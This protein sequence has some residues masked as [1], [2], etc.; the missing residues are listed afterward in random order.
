MADAINNVL[1]NENAAELCAVNTDYIHACREVAET[2]VWGSGIV[3][4]SERAS[5][6]ARGCAFKETVKFYMPPSWGDATT[7]SCNVPVGAEVGC[8]CEGIDMGQEQ[9]FKLA[10]IKCWGMNDCEATCLNSE[11]QSP[12]DIIQNEL[13][14]P[15]FIGQMV[16][17]LLG[18]AVAIQQSILAA[19]P[20]SPYVDLNMDLGTDCLDD[21]AFIDA[22]AMTDCGEWDGVLMHK[23]VVLK[24]KKRRAIE[25]ICSTDGGPSIFRTSEGTRIISVPK[26]VGDM[27]LKDAAGNYVS[28]FFKN[29][30]FEY[31]EGTI[32]TPFERFRNPQANNCSGA[33]SIYYR[34]LY[35]MRPRG[36][37]FDCQPSTAND[38]FVSNG[39]LFDPSKWDIT[40]PAEN[41]G[42]GFV[43]AGCA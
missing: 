26:S 42:L 32:R 40:V 16:G 8:D 18:S 3:G 38:M 23:D 17:K 6:F 22:N 5:R 39:D 4:T 15:Y 35:V 31:G 34:R 41:F 20:S 43:T 27:Y 36:T 33:E 12:L 25:C 11:G 9:L 24:A 28:I 37:V 13:V 14:G 29:G 21:C 1:C 30:A 2:T 7:L 10:D 19:G